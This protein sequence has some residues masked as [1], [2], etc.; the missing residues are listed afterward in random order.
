MNKVS[1]DHKTLSDIMHFMRNQNLSLDEIIAASKIMVKQREQVQWDLIDNLQE[2]DWTQQ[3]SIIDHW[4][5][6]QI[7]KLLDSKIHSSVIERLAWRA[8]QLN[9][10][11]LSKKI[12]DNFLKWPFH[13]MKFTIDYRLP[14]EA[15]DY[16][17]QILLE[18]QIQHDKKHGGNRAP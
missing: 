4:T 1:L 2:L 14:Q 3:F 16:Y 13:D 6:E 11:T 17:K 12:I 9:N 15:K 10:T 7:C 8:K 5:V 18:R